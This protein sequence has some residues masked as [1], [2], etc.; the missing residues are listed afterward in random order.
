M[1]GL[2][3]CRF[4]NTLAGCGQ[5]FHSGNTA[6][7]SWTEI[8]ELGLGN[9]KLE[10]VVGVGTACFEVQN[11]ESSAVDTD[12]VHS[13]DSSSAVDMDIVHSA[14]SVWVVGDCK[15]TAVGVGVAYEG[16]IADTAGPGDCVPHKFDKP[17]VPE[18]VGQL[19]QLCV[20]RPASI[21]HK[22]FLQSD[23]YLDLFNCMSGGFVRV[24][25]NS[26]ARAAFA[27]CSRVVGDIFI[28]CDL[29]AGGSP[30]I[31]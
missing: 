16:S 15:L 6:T 13:V 5:N 8:V 18:L 7:D 17:L 3:L 14:G 28:T 2:G 10:G 9:K 21:F 27:A 24:R 11:C 23:Q 22:V 4:P 1:L 20:Q 31:K 29:I 30:W 12:I 26:S 25:L 19:C